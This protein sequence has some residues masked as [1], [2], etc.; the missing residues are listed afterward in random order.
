MLGTCVPSRSLVVV[1]A[2]TAQPEVTV[3]PMATP[4][5]GKT[6]DSCDEAAEAGEERVRGSQGTGRG[7]PAA[8]VP[9]ARD[10]DGD[11]VVCER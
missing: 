5:S 3:T 7:F 2:E 9:S 8:M 4:V 6:Y 10:G 11:G 1:R